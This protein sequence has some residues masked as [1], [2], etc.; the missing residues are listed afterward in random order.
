VITNQHVSRVRML[1]VDSGKEGVGD[2][3]SHLRNIAEDYRK[4]FEE[5]PGRLI[6]I[7]VMTDSDNTKTEVK[8]I[9]GDIELIHLK[10]KRASTTPLIQ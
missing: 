7:G 4:S 1:V 6:G 10:N 8:A 2:W 3:R 5:S 9:Y